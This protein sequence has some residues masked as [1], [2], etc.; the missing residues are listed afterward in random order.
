MAVGEPPVPSFDQ[1]HVGSPEQQRLLKRLQRLIL[2]ALVLYIV[3]EVCEW[4]LPSGIF[5]SGDEKESANVLPHISIPIGGASAA[6][7][8]L[9]RVSGIL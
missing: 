2:I 7:Q 1:N 4:L 8:D 5:Q 9:W 6:V 3:G